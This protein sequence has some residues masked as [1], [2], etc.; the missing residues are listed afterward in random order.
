MERSVPFIGTEQGADQVQYQG[1]PARGPRAVH[2]SGRL[3]AAQHTVS[4]PC[5]SSMMRCSCDYLSQGIEPVAQDYTSPSSVAQRRHKVG[6]PCVDVLVDE[7]PGC[8]ASAVLVTP[9]W[10]CGRRHQT[11]QVSIPAGFPT[12]VCAAH[13]R[14]SPVM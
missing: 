6:H 5:T 2:S 14:S 13:L 4:S 11:P 3:S 10:P 1:C 9:P 7:G 12:T 8:G